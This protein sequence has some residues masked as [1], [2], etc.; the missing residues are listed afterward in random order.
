MNGEYG[1]PIKAGPAIN[2]DGGGSC[3]YIAPDESFLIFSKEWN[4]ETEALY[5]SFRAKDGQWLPP[6]A[7]S[8]GVGSPTAIVSPDGKYLFTGLA[9]ME[10]KFIEEQRPK[11]T[12]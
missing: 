2:G 4:G 12:K 5:I 3:P 11:E 6:T 1:K 10:A 8:K 7:F 9:W